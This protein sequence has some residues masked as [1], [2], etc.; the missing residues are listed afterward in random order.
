MEI[1]KLKTFL[2]VSQ[3][4]N[5]THAAKKL[6]FAQS[7]VTSHIKSL[8]TELESL[9]FERLGKKIILTPSGETLKI[10]ARKIIDTHDEA[11]FLIKD[12]DKSVLI[13]IGAQE[14]QCTYRLPSI[15]KDFQ[16]NHPNVKIIFKPANSDDIIKK[17]L[18][19]GE[20]DL[21]FFTD[22]IK[23]IENLV[24][25]PL[26]QDE[27]VLVASPHQSIH[28]H[29][30]V[31][32][33]QLKDTPL[34]MTERGCSYRQVFEEV[35]D[36]KSDLNINKLEFV[37]IEAI[38]QCAIAGIGIGILPLMVVEKEIREGNLVKIKFEKQ[39]PPIF[40]QIAWH[41]DKSIN[42]FLKAFIDL[43]NEHIRI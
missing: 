8:E 12:S 18:L 24:I 16:K 39:F 34:L 19:E 4:L 21:A 11:E 33:D 25:E 3:T 17:Q 7:S 26:I 36:R 23:Q 42:S 2:I 43:A 38:K 9:L 22:K 28:F 29:S 10:Y 35:V 37:S 40:T 31:S 14:S 30:N 20:L 6:N 13:K 15:L 1:K 41:K 32:F 5:F 27:L